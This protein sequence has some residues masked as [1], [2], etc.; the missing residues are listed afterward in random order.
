MKYSRLVRKAYLK[1][2]KFKAIERQTKRERREGDPDYLAFIRTLPC[3]APG[4]L[5]RPPSQPHHSTGAGMGTKSGDRDTMPLCW[6]CHRAFHDGNGRF[7]SWS[8]LDRRLWQEKMVE[9][10]QRAFAS[11]V[12]AAV[13]Q[14]SEATK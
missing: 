3:C 8:R 10:C 9:R 2:V 5:A 7:E 6:K 14:G 1:R 13:Y 4:C 11:V 12:P